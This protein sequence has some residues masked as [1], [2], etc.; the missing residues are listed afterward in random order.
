MSKLKSLMMQSSNY[1]SFK[2]LMTPPLQVTLV[3]PRP[4]MQCKEIFTWPHMAADILKYV[5]GCHMCRRNKNPSVK[6]AGLLQPIGIPEKSWG[7][8]TTD[9]ITGLPPTASGHD[10]ILAFVDKLQNM[11]IWH[12][13]MPHVLLRDGLSFLCACSSVPRPARTR[14]LRQRWSF[15]W[16]L[17][18]GSC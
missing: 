8:V 11:C 9:F 15:H 12:Q 3:T 5:Q 14:P 16:Q 13:A 2:K 7:V 18:S 1:I 4:C 17:Q 6:P 10:A